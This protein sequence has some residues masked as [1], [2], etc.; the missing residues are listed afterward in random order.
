[1]HEHHHDDRRLAWPASESASPGHDKH[2]GHTPGMFLSRFWISLGL[3]G[4]IVYLS[5]H[6][7][8]WFR[9]R[10]I[11]FPLD[12]AITPI[13]ATVL[14]GYA[15]SV[16][17]RGAVGE[18]RNRVPGMMTLISLA[19][20]VAY[21]YSAAVTAG[22]DGE[23]L[24]WE[25][26]TLLD[27]MLL[28]HWLEMRSI[29]AASQA[30][31]HLAAMVPSTAHRVAD[32]GRIEDVDVGVLVPG[33]QILVRPGEQV[34]VDARVVDGAS[35]VSEAFLTGESRPVDKFLD[36]EIVAGSVNGEGALTA[37]VVRTGA[38][39]TLRQIMRLVAA[40]Q[41][42]RGRYQA[43]ADRAARWLTI[44]AIA[45]ATPT[46]VAWLA[47]SDRGVGFG[48]TRAVTVLVIACPHALGLAIPLVTT[49]ATTLAARHG[50]LVR[51]REAFER[52]RAIRLVAFDKT[53]T[54]TEGRFDVGVITVVGRLER[55]VLAIAAALE[56]ASEHPLAAAIV[57]T[58]EHRDVE[59][60]AAAA[61]TASPGKGITGT[62]S[63]V[64]YRIGKPEWAEDRGLR[65]APP[66]REALD[67]AAHR[68]DSAVLLFDDQA[69]LGVFALS[70]IVRPTA[71]RAV[72]R[73]RQQ[74]VETVM[75]TGDG[76]AVAAT[77][78]AEL[79]IDRHH[80]RILPE[81]KARLVTNLRDTSPI[82]F[83]GDGINDGPALLAAD[84]GVAIGAGTNVAIE[85]ADLVLVDDDPEDVVRALNLSRATGRKMTQNLLWATGYNVVAIPL[86]AGVAAG[87][88][89][90]LE[91]AVGALLMSTST[92]IVALN[93]MLLRRTDLT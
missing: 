37:T 5:D 62:V 81:D 22:L 56:R 65:L 72:S 42:S 79:G 38:D 82:A 44:V 58:A 84:L 1:M 57:A 70:D 12:D 2:A 68:G 78:A 41:E 27:V 35:S 76:A 23:P 45:V 86:A 73:L 28:G 47:M 34:P 30:L 55:E 9:Y 87:A 50:I 39:T 10:A 15:G 26:A 7:Q 77:V 92:V 83:V 11:D 67:A 29:V 75:I 32:D 54:L 60:P 93:A 74:G 36:S 17:L 40:A 48:I 63:G 46:L 3:T 71:R 69:V 8:E 33:D 89:V 16:F 90:L 51:N 19:I 21:A 31:D 4:P 53:G 52:G 25:L 91:P 43:L 13:A 14:F 61:V 88:G 66:L 49:N 18:I 24:Y 80:A 59:I 85:S 6:F 64:T 20:T